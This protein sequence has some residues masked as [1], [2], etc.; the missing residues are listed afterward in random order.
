MRDFVL[1]VFR[2]CRGR[3]IL[4]VFACFLVMVGM[5]LARL[6]DT[7]NGLPTDRG[8]SF[9]TI[10]ADLKNRSLLGMTEEQLKARFGT[11]QVDP[12]GL[13]IFPTG[14][15]TKF[16]LEGVRDDECLWVSFRNGQVVNAGLGTGDASTGHLN[17][18]MC[19][20]F[21]IRKRI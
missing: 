5:I 20:T 14:S 19:G 16:P 7:L 2:Q 18:P 21:M 3:T 4:L 11:Y 17:G 6:R 8:P 15:F 10:E 12:D 13:W 1:A 9:Q